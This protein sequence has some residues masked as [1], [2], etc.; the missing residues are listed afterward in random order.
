MGGLGFKDFESFNIALLAKQYW[1][2]INNPNALWAKVLKG[3]Y[4]PN[5]ECMEAVRGS[6]PSWIWCSLL[7][8]KQLIQ[9]GIQWNV[10][11]GELISFWDDA[12]VPDLMGKK[13]TPSTSPIEEHHRVVDFIDQSTYSWNLERL[14]QNVPEAEVQAICK[15]PVSSSKSS[16]KII[17]RHTKSGNYTVKSGYFQKVRKPVRGN[18][19]SCSFVPSSTMWAKFWGIAT[20]PKVLMFMWKVVKNWV[21]CKANLFKRKCASTPLCPICES[22]P[23]SIEHM[24]FH[25]PWSRAVWF[26]S[27]K[28]YWV[29]QFEIAAADRWMENLICGD[30]AK[31]TSK[32]DL[33][34]IFQLCWSIWKARNNFV[35]NGK[36]PIPEEVIDQ[37]AKANT[38]Y[39]NAVLCRVRK[40]SNGTVQMGRWTLPPPSVFKVNCD[41]ALKSSS[42]LA[43]FGVIV[44]D[45]GGSAQVW[46]CG[47]VRV[48]SAIVIEASLSC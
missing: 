32:E 47:R 25:C 35:F 12:W 10:G 39:L 14:R 34:A 16:D 8:G 9:K 6:S 30:L 23:E 18:S 19:P 3:L 2:L 36:Y 44:R 33:G 22:A 26:G 38:D 4:F 37:G 48:S 13:V 27:G 28:I 20:A 7:E 41:G 5:K 1:R 11:S 24:L 42:S 43:A 17:W 29:N 40:V 46:R 15:I 45:F 31:E 21:A